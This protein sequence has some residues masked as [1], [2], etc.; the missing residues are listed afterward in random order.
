MILLVIVTSL[1]CNTLWMYKV[2]Q[3]WRIVFY[4]TNRLHKHHWSILCIN[5]KIIAFCIHRVGCFIQCSYVCVSG[6]MSIVSDN[7]LIMQ[8]VFIITIVPCSKVSCNYACCVI[9]FYTVS[10]HIVSF[11]HVESDLFIFNINLE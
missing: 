7:D 4:H 10:S 6:C 8:Y 11:V 2:S 5:F 9:K 3:L 1:Y